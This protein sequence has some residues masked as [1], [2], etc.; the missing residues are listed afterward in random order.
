MTQNTYDALIII[1]LAISVMFNIYNHIRLSRAMTM[2]GILVFRPQIVLQEARKL[3]E[4]LDLN[5]EEP[6]DE[7]A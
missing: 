6:I 2:L 1:A 4:Q 3:A 5:M 7:T